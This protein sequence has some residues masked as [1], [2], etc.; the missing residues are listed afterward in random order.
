MLTARRAY[1]VLA[2]M[3]WRP[4]PRHVSRHRGNWRWLKALL[5]AEIGVVARYVRLAASEANHARRDDGISAAHYSAISR[6]AA[7]ENAVRIFLL[8]MRP[9]SAARRSR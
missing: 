5:R 2:A 7:R 4:L 6:G 8:L 1:V 9:S 3:S